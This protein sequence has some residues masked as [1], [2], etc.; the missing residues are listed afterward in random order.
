MTQPTILIVEDDA[1]LAMFL[2]DML[3]RLNYSVFPSIATGEEAVR[4]SLQ[5]QPDLVL[6]DIQLSGEMNGITAARIIAQKTGIPIIFLTS[7]DQSSVVE[8][9]KTAGAYGYLIKPVDERDLGTNIE[10]ALYK[11]KI[12]QKLRESEERLR[13]VLENSLDASYK[14]NLKTNK[15]DYLSPVFER[16]SGYTLAEMENLP[17]EALISMMHPDDQAD[18]EHVVSESLSGISGATY[19]LE[20]RFRHK[21]GS[22]RWFLDRFTFLRDKDNL[23]LAR[24]GSIEDISARKHTEETL[25]KSEAQYQRLLRTLPSGVVVHTAGQIVW[26]NDAGVRMFGGNLPQ[27]FIGSYLIDRVHPDYRNIVNSRQKIMLNGSLVP[28]IE[29]KLLRRDGSAFDAE[30]SALPITYAGKP[31]VLALFND[32]TERKRSEIAIVSLGLRNQTLLNTATDGIHILDEHGNLM[33]ANPAFCNMLGFTHEEILNLNVTDWDMQWSPDELLGK[34]SEL[35]KHPGLFQTR[36]RKKD[37]SLRDVEINAVGVTLE[38]QNYLYAAARDV[39]ERKQIEDALKM[40]ETKLRAILD[41]SSDAIGVYTNGI[42]ELCNPAAVRMFAVSSP[43]ELIG[44]PILKVIALDERQ[45]IAGY[46]RSRVQGGDAPTSYVT[47]GLR[48]DGTEFDMD[49]TLSSFTLENRLHA[50]MILRDITDRKKA[51]TALLLAH[52]ELEQRVLERTADLQ[53]ANNSLEKASR[54]KDEFLAIMSHELRTPLTGIIGMSQILLSDTFGELNEKQT[55]ALMNIEK[56]GQHLHEI[57]DDILDYSTL[58][59]S[60]MNLPLTS[61][62]LTHACNACIQTVDVQA[63]QKKLTMRVSISPEIITLRAD[64][65][66][67]RQIIGN[68]LS[69]AV[70]FTPKKGEI[71]LKVTGDRE[72]HQVRISVSDTGIGIKNEDLARLFQPFQQLDMRLARKFNGTGLGLAMV[73]LLTE[74][75]SG[76]VEVESEFGKGSCFTVILPWTP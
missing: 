40:S 49:V 19:Q 51:E 54:A 52:A 76:S 42:W 8:D 72:A 1:I 14:R 39:T 6:M 45:R 31:S 10:I 59:A 13:E 47:R 22:Y 15:Y 50:L 56:S 7:F 63:A 68:L 11:H 28:L 27:E 43:E 35:I 69:N 53:A 65:R 62:S 32:I 71:E 18:M 20:Y 38:G 34:I 9:A 41:C 61:F 2:Q 21:D 66:R 4:F 36:H 70:K 67:I 73:K 64:E 44:T 24:I 25:Q 55:A 57:I 23:P 29:E 26:A 58:Q 46:V 74:I 60:N 33:D 3:S 30:V 16:L 17:I 48:M 37:G 12:D 75:H 5:N